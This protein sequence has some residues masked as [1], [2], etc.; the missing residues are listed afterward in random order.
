MRAH[1]PRRCTPPARH[2]LARTLRPLPGAL[3]ALLLLA[4]PAIA[5]D[6]DDEV[7]ER[8]EYFY[9]QRAYPF[10]RV[11]AG[12]LQRGW[13]QMMGRWPAIF[14]RARAAAANVISGNAALAAASEWSPLGPAPIDVE[15][16]GRIATVAIHPVNSSIIYIG[17]AQGG[18][19]KTTNGGASWIPLTDHEC[20][21]AMGS[22]VIDPVNPQIVYAGT[23]EMNFSAD[24]YYGCGVLRTTDGGATWTQQGASVFDS[25]SGGARIA[26]LL[27]DPGTAGSASATT[28]YAATTVGLYVSR[29][30]GATWTRLIDGVFTDL[31]MHPTDARTLYAA[32]GTP[33]GSPANGIYR[34]TDGGATWTQ[35][36]AGFPAVN[37]GRIALALAPSA[38][39]V[40]YAAVQDQLAGGGGADGQLLGIWK[41]TDAGATWLRVTATGA[42]CATQCWYNLVIA[43]DPLNPDIVYF[44]G[45]LL[46]RSDDGG[47]I[48]RSILRTIHVDQHAISFDPK[49]PSTVIVGNDGGIYRSTDRGGTWQSLN[50]NLALTQFYSG[51]ALHPSDAS[52]ALGGTQDN[53]TLEYSGVSRWASVLG[54]D[55]GFTAIDH[56]NPSFS[57]A[58]TQW[59]VG[60][61]F[62][63]PRLRVGSGQFGIRKVAGIDMNDRALFI[64]PL[65]LDPT[66]PA[67]VYF[68]TFRLYRTA[69]RGDLWTA[70]S[71]DLSRGAGRVS[72]IAPAAADPA[73]I[74]VGTNDG[75][76]QVTR[77]GG[78]SWQLRTGGLP[79]R[80]FTDIAVDVA[81]PAIALATVSGFGTG[82]VFRTTDFGIT[83]S[84][85][86]ADLPDVPVNA[87]LAHPGLGGELFIGTDL[88]VFRRD[89]GATSWTP[90]VDGLPNVAV[91]DLAYSNQSGLVVAGTHGRGMFSFRP[92]IAADLIIAPD[93]LRFAALDDTV[94]L[95]AT[96]FDTLGGAFPSPTFFWRSLDTAVVSVDNSGL[97]RSRANGT[98]AIIASFAGAADTVRVSVSQVIVAIVDA[99]DSVALVIGERRQLGARAVDARGRTVT[100]AVLIWS[101]SNPASVTVD[102]GGNVAGLAVGNARVSATVSTFRD[103]VSVSVAPPSVA[104]ITAAGLAAATPVSSAAG[105][106]LLLLRLRFS[107]A[108]IEAVEITRVGFDVTGDDADATLQLI[109]DRADDGTV[110]AADSVIASFNTTL[111]PG[112]TQR[113]SLAPGGLTVPASGSAAV[114]VALRLSGRSPNGATFQASFL[115]QQTSSIGVRSSAADRLVQPAAPV[116]SGLVQATLLAADEILTFSENPVRSDRVIFNFR[117]PPR[118]AAVYTITGRLVVDLTRGITQEGRLEWDL[119]NQD[120]DLVAPGVYLVVFNVGGTVMRERLFVLRRGDESGV[121]DSVR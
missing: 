23:G 112:T 102:P 32:L 24:S 52:V 30:S 14:A 101:S 68:G 3:A 6:P 118:V 79:N 49:S 81:N 5:Q 13:R 110:G 107:V 16:S 116:A 106:R 61:G 37:V 87:V 108:G 11:P 73:T 18:V 64:P 27:I 76:L 51:I 28:V 99:P 46:Y 69:N 82:H 104:T 57:W 55:G 109:R 90:L 94:R 98:T 7:M 4:V 22:L 60:S 119:R 74:Y 83:W 34:T 12:A 31:L 9:D 95:R 92:I 42:D 20:S 65:V 85:I 21:T 29:N 121:R 15:A 71:P 77:D 41:S 105:S 84:D 45:V 58:E 62:S 120:G 38:P 25:N 103:S 115:P 1:R 66:D 113:V 70:I 2:G 48:F 36:S 39:N 75:N 50:T 59:S 96:A 17:G 33:G 111:R 35:L 54:G 93:S 89:A 43:T 117:E 40:L 72:A 44:G 26:K 78:S 114:L 8:W 91:F 67:V 88:G 53:G 97:V 47:A 19:W 10:A 100:G 80:V 63:G 56:R 86:S